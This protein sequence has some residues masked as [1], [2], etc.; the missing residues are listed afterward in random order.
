MSVEKTAFM[1]SF[2][3]VLPMEKCQNKD[4]HVLIFMLI[5][6]K[7]VYLTHNMQMFLVLRSMFGIMEVFHDNL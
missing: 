1:A 4:D 3:L 2:N 7:T 5:K 6:K